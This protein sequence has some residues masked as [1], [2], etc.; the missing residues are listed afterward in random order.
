MSDQRL[1]ILG[2]GGFIGRVLADH[3]GTIIPI[4]SRDIDLSVD[5]SGSILAAKLRSDDVMVFASAIT[6]DKGKDVN[7]FQKN[8][9]MARQVSEALQRQSVRQLVYISS[10]AVFAENIPP[11]TEETI[12]CPNSLYGT[13]HLA[14][15]QIMEQAC[16]ARGI[17]LLIVRLCAVYGPGDTHNSYGPNRFLKSALTSGS[18]SLF[19][20]GAE[21]RPHAHIDDVGELIHALIE[22]GTTGLVHAI[23][24]PSIS[25]REVA[26][27]VSGVV[28]GV[29]I[30]TSQPSSP[31]THKHFSSARLQKLLPAFRFRNLKESLVNQTSSS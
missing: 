25:F 27:V 28:G 21:M 15:E 2:A 24:S 14:R 8:C 17:P 13:M 18:I 23:P 1:V 12:P 29:S 6:P 16:S 31:P 20:E 10:D 4:S 30:N 11:I 19:G 7:A 3:N 9:E 5:G 22:L 26:E